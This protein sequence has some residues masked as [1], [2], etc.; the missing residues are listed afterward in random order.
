MTVMRD[1]A[2]VT[3]RDSVDGTTH[4]RGVPHRRLATTTR[5]E[6]VHPEVMAA[7]A[8]IMRDGERLQIV[9]ASEVLLVPRRR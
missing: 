1:S 5:A 4:R 9:S 7:A 8:R 2:S 3:V 6:Q